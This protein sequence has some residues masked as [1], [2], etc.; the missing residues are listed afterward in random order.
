[1]A[2]ENN[3]A[4]RWVLA[5]GALGIASVVTLF[6]TLGLDVDGAAGAARVV[7]AVTL[8]VALV[9]GMVLR[10]THQFGSTVLLIAGAAAPIA[11]WYNLPLA[12][13]LSVLIAV[14]VWLTRPTVCSSGA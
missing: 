13:V 8:G 12:Y 10:G 1:M 6:V 4:G 7:G 14:V 5:V 11:A 3:T 9:A 2:S